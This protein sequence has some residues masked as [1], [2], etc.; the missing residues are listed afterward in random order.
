MKASQ[1]GDCGLKSYKL[2]L[3]SL[4]TFSTSM[5]AG[6]FPD[7]PPYVGC[8]DHDPVRGAIPQNPHFGFA[9]LHCINLHKSDSIRILQHVNYKII[10]S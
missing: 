10:Y 7:H 6:C 2:I 5:V 8:Q 4:S 1:T 3:N 9:G